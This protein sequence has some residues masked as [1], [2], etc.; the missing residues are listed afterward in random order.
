YLY[1]AQFQDGA[2]R[3][4]A[5]PAVAMREKV[6]RL[7]AASRAFV[8]EDLTGADLAG[9]DLRGADF[10]GAMLENANL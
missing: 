5:A 1:T 6:K 9:L 3:L 4:V 8:N 10:T 2:P 7:Y